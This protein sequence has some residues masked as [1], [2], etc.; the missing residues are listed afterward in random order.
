MVILSNHKNA[1]LIKLSLG[2]HTGHFIKPIMQMQFFSN[3]S[4]FSNILFK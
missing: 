4:V 1:D 3:Q 2:F